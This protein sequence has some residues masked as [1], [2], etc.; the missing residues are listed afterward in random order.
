MLLVV[1]S[2]PVLLACSKWEK[3]R[4]M[5]QKATQTN[6]VIRVDIVNTGSTAKNTMRY[7]RSIILHFILFQKL[8][9]ILP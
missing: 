3:R 9:I 7:F 1:Y 5:C 4:N 8:V 6:D 2:V